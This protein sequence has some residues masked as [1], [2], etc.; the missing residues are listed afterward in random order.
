MGSEGREGLNVFE[1]KEEE[2]GLVDWEEC[3][4]VGFV[5]WMGW[6]WEGLVVGISKDDWFK[7]LVVDVMVEGF[8]WLEG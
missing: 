2:E 5:Y 3:E 4:G 7:D 1:V 6:F 8:G